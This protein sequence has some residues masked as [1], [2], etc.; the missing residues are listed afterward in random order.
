MAHPADLVDRLVEATN[1]HDLDAIVACFGDDYRNETPVH[2]LRG[3]EGSGQV[4]KNWEQIFSWVPDIRATVLASAVD[5]DD[6]W[7]EWEMCGT[8]KDGSAHLMRGVIIFT[9]RGDVVRRARF[10]L[11]PVEDGTGDVNVAVQQQV[12]R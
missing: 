4:R 9:V 8:R 5:G 6:V 3:F 7:S 11:E 2:P 12:V 10:Y 1:A